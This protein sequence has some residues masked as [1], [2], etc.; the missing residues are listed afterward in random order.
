M[1][2]RAVSLR[3]SSL[4]QCTSTPAPRALGCLPQQLGDLLVGE[5]DGVRHG[6]REQG[7]ERRPGPGG[8]AQR[9]QGVHP[10]ARPKAVPT[11]AEPAQTSARVRDQSRVAHAVHLQHG[12]ERQAWSRPT[13]RASPGTSTRSEIRTP[14]SCPA[15]T[16]AAHAR[17]S[18]T[19]CGS[20]PRR[21]APPA[22]S[23]AAGERGSVSATASR[24]ARSS[25]SGSG[26]RSGSARPPAPRAPRAASRRPVRGS[27][28]RPP[29][30]A[31]RHARRRGHRR[32]GRATA[33]RAR[34]VAGRARP[35][36]PRRRSPG[37]RRHG[38]RA[39]EDRQRG[40]HRQ[41]RRR[42]R[43]PLDTVLAG[44]DDGQLLDGRPD[45]AGGAAAVGPP[46]GDGAGAGR[47]GRARTRHS[48]G[49]VRRSRRVL[50]RES[51]AQRCRIPQI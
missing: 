36:R 28:P 43:H 42:H 35:P 10:R 33:A 32:T 4:G 37:G 25:H 11:P 45:L 19:C 7:R 27:A 49:P 12:T 14:A 29:L 5:F 38:T 30:P 2:A 41:Q 31:D 15:A 40:A 9:E 44:Q 24:K 47:V 39:R 51:S 3:A 26:S 13:R 6:R 21:P 34:R 23:G 48:S 1:T 50:P 16:S 20:A 8:A 18:G 22:A 17:C 46:E